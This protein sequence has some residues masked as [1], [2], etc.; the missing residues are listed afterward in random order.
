MQQPMR[1]R[2][3]FGDDFLDRLSQAEA[4]DTQES[5][6]QHSQRQQ[7]QQ[8]AQRQMMQQQQQMQQQ[9]HMQQQRQQQELQRQAQMQ[10]MQMHNEYIAENIL[11]ARYSPDPLRVPQ[12]LV[13]WA[14]YP[15]EESTWEPVANVPAE[16]VDRYRQQQQQQKAMQQQQQMRQMQQNQ[17]NQQMQMRRGASPRRSAPLQPEMVPRLG[18]SSSPRSG[19]FAHPESGNRPVAPRGPSPRRNS[20][21]GSPSPRMGGSHH[22]NSTAVLA[23]PGGHSSICFG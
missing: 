19:G 10:Q 8:Q 16:L 18:R 7:M 1:A 17:Q 20:A 3:G 23:P 4:R 13:K 22:R 14:G 11:G 9:R 21:Y 15:V 2:S 6:R 5:Q 12:L